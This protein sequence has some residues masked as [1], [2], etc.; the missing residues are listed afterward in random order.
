MYM[1][2]AISLLIGYLSL[3]QEV[4]WVRI[5]GFY[6]QNQ[7]Q[8]FAFVL[9]LFLAGIALG[10][11]CGKLFAVR[12][13]NL[14]YFI[15]L[16]LC[17]V[18]V[19]DVSLPSLISMSA[20]SRLDLVLIAILVVI[21]A[22]LKATIFPYVHQLGSRTDSRVGR[23]VSKVY[24]MN[25]LG[26]AGAP[27]FTG[28]YLMDIFSAGALILLF[29]SATLLLGAVVLVVSACFSTKISSQIFLAVFSICIGVYLLVH[30]EPADSALMRSL[31]RTDDGRIA[32][33]LENKHGVIHVVKVESGDDIVFGGNVYDGRI[34]TSLAANSNLI[35][36]AYLLHAL[37]PKPR[38]VLVIG[39]STGAWCRVVGYSPKVEDIDVIEINPGYF[40]LIEGYPQVSYI[41]TDPRVNFYVDD[42]RRWVRRN[43]E[44]KYDIIVMNTTYH[45]RSNITNL[46]SNEMMIML[47]DRLAVGGILAFNATGSGDAFYTAGEVFPHAYR[48][49]NF[50]YASDHDFRY[51]LVNVRGRLSDLRDR[52]VPVFD[53]N[54]SAHLKSIDALANISFVSIGESNL[55]I[56]RPPELI[57][58]E[59]MIIE[60]K[61]GKSIF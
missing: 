16:L 4:V 55:Q 42:A 32:T 33:V 41:L 50:V 35:D 14:I 53:L 61:F 5:V 9:T 2:W 51:Q 7:P 39:L 56:G 46:L 49:R 38:R 28:F 1:A 57:T 44:N 19:F 37:H 30:L 21:S 18:G 27:L 23:S 31:T 48:Y 10:A 54:S 20:N 43:R 12:Y 58:D 26:S 59:N 8:A 36:R 40:R 47:R 52:E 13:Q 15:G 45:W 34:N 60:F 25:I 6:L 22:A 24:F 3:S 17:L 11:T 29:G